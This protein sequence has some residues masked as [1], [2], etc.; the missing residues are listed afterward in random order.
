MRRRYRK[1]GLALVLRHQHAV[2][3]PRRLVAGQVIG[4]HAVDSGLGV[5]KA[6]ARRFGRSPPPA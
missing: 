2:F 3:A 6:G 5:G 1:R 4:H